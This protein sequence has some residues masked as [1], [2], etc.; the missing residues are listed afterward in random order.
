MNDNELI[1]PAGLAHQVLKLDLFKGLSKENSWPENR[2]V[3][4]EG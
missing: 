1:N 3:A 2:T 4:S